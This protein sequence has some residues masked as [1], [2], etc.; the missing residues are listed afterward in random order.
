MR[1]YALVCVAVLGS[2]YPVVAT[3][4]DEPA[5]KEDP[6]GPIA[7]LKAL[8]IPLE[9]HRYTDDDYYSIS[10]IEPD[11]PAAVERITLGDIKSSSDPLW[12]LPDELFDILPKFP[13]LRGIHFEYFYLEP[14]KLR[15]LKAV[16]T[17][18]SFEVHISY[19]GDRKSFASP[20]D[21]D[22]LEDLP[23]LES[24]RLSSSDLTNEM[25]E[26]LLVLKSL[27]RLHLGWN[28]KIDERVFPVFKKMTK[29]ERLSLYH[30]SFVPDRMEA[31]RYGAGMKSFS[32]SAPTRKT[33]P[34]KY[35]LDDLKEILT[36]P[37]E[38]WATHHQTDVP[39][40]EILP[41]LPGPITWIEVNVYRTMLNGRDAKN[42]ERFRIGI[43]RKLSKD[44]FAL[45]GGMK[46]LKTLDITDSDGSRGGTSDDNLGLLTGLEKLEYL[47]I[48]TERVL[49]D[50]SLEVLSTMPALKKVELRNVNLGPEGLAW[51]R[52]TPELFRLQIQDGSIDGDALEDV[53]LARSLSFLILGKKEYSSQR[54]AGVKISP[55]SRV[56]TVDGIKTLYL[57]SSKL[58]IEN[59][60]QIGRFPSLGT[61]TL[62]G[63][64][65]EEHMLQLKPLKNLRYITAGTN[66]R[67]LQHLRNIRSLYVCDPTGYDNNV[68]EMAD[69]FGWSFYGCS[70][71][72][73][74]TIGKAGVN[75]NSED[76]D[77]DRLKAGTKMPEKVEGQ[78]YLAEGQECRLEV[79][80]IFGP[81]ERD[82]LTID[83]RDFP[84]V[85]YSLYLTDC[86]IETLELVGWKPGLISLWGKSHLGKIVIS[87]VPD[88]TNY[89]LQYHYLEG[90]K[91]LTV[92]ESDRV[93][94]IVVSNC[95]E[96]DSLKLDGFYPKLEQVELRNLDRLKYFA[97][98]YRGDAPRLQYP[99]NAH[100]GVSL[101]ALRLLKLPGTAVGNE[102]IEFPKNAQTGKT[103]EE[104]RFPP[105]VVE[106]DLRDTPI[107]DEW[108]EHL[109]KLPKLKVLRIGECK[110]LTDEA[111][112]RF[113]K[114]RP[115]VKLDEVSV[116]RPGE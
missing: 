26:K 93:S 36:F 51:L 30:T 6:S 80:R 61:L 63:D 86:R 67:G 111:K 99:P 7:Q 22:W 90:V 110:N 5:A 107:D 8:G 81:I 27:K 57:W 102:T 10:Q 113:R 13:N 48:E 28:Y 33:N 116:H 112:A 109:A 46:S 114:D 49:T 3:S 75:W 78:E 16:P 29:L 15:R 92:P 43:Y 87:D 18:R 97:A 94:Q 35:T 96:L 59:C 56:F 47:T 17:L 70:S 115:D 44:D 45:I 69:Q 64:L 105:S 91:T 12:T 55:P 2:L 101:P 31:R 74:D 108:L 66:F 21:L 20:E 25:V 52:E 38:K 89:S 40:A 65:T 76:L 19:K 85:P 60:E 83:A 71:G 58:S 72:C 23:Q 88:D 39:L 106:V 95:R 104:P 103:M 32:Y 100:W 77:G 4:A 34:Y 54:V 73:C 98:P 42:D 14:E 68:Q 79:F 84:R 11:D 9:F 1:R 41:L 62:Y 24:L 53:G 37:R 50:R 82:R